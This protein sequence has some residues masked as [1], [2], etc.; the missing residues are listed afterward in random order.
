MAS[1]SWDD[2]YKTIRKGTFPPAVYLYGVEDPLKDEALQELLDAA[3]DPGLRD[4][5]LDIR[6]ASSLD[7]DEVATL[8]TTLPMM[9]DRRVVIIRDV[10]AWNK[11]AKAKQAVLDCLAKPSPETLVVLIQGAGDPEKAKDNDP[12]ADL[13]KRAY[14]VNCERLRPDRAARW[15]TKEAGKLGLTLTPEAVDHLVKSLDAELGPLRSELGKLAGLAGEDALDVDAVSALLGVRAGETVPDWRDAVMDEAAGRA[16]AV[17][18]ALLAQTG[19]SGVKL[20]TTLGLALVGTALARALRDDG[21]RGRVLEAA[22]LD[23]IKRSRLWGIDYRTSAAQWTRW[24]ERWTMT[25][26]QA[27]IRAATEAD[28]ALKGTTL[29]DEAG[30]LTDLVMRLAVPMQEAA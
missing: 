22:V 25:R 11:R 18:P 30:I 7:P 12:D 8:L 4:F 29:S 28:M 16:C 19:V 20:V 10:E 23:V 1:H 15:L 17:L 26:L 13:A 5:N 24:S 27:G 9:A 2:F 14:T 3:L 6:S 21:K